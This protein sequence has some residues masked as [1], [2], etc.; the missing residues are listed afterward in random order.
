MDIQKLAA[1]ESNQQPEEGL[2]FMKT[3]TRLITLTALLA[4]TFFVSSAMACTTDAWLG[5]ATTGTLADNPTNG[6]ARV[7]GVCGLAVTGTGHVIDNSPAAEATFIG[8]FYVFPKPLP[9]GTHVLFTAY[10]DDAGS[11]LFEITYDGSLF[12][13]DAS[14]AGDICG[15][16]GCCPGRL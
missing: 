16:G 8:R 2:I 5:G 9:A 7:S 14:A 10:S 3:F 11:K 15:G 1:S 13:I 12:K 4:G 6:V